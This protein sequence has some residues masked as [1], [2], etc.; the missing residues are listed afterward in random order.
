[1]NATCAT[2]DLKCAFALPFVAL[3]LSLGGHDSL[4]NHLHRAY[5]K[6]WE[7]MGLALADHFPGW[8]QAPVF[9]G[10]SFWIKGPKELDARRLAEEA[11]QESIIIEPGDIFFSDPDEHRNY[12]RLGFSSIPEDR[13]EPGIRL[14]ADIADRQLQNPPARVAE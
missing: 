11:L 6:R 7:I 2:V 9:G 1:M 10:T 8:S 4:I 5:L 3:F 13:I 14:L 12:F